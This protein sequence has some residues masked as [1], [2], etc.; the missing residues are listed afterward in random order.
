MK[1]TKW[2]FAPQAIATVTAG[3]L[4]WVMYIYALK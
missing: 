2:M 4:V 3:R 1:K